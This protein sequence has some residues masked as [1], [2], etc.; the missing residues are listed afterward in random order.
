M[1]HLERRAPLLALAVLHALAA[2]HGWNWDWY[3]LP[4]LLPFL[5]FVEDTVHA[6]LMPCWDQLA[7]LRASL[8]QPDPEHPG[9]AC[10]CLGS[11]L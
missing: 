11:S 9:A 4:E 3:Q 5:E 2:R 1:R 10:V 7:L 6:P 8:Q